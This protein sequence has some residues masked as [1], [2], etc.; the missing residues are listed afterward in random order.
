MV[1]PTSILE[2]ADEVPPM[3]LSSRWTSSGRQVSF[4]VLLAITSLACSLSGEAHADQT[5]YTIAFLTP[6][7]PETE[8]R[9]HTAFEQGL[10]ERGYGPGRNI[11]ILYRFAEGHDELL[12]GLVA[13]LLRLDVDVLLTVG[14]PATRAAQRATKTVPIV[15]VTVLDPV[16]AGFVPPCCSFRGQDP[17]GGRSCQPAGRATDPVRARCKR[18]HR[19][20]A[21]H[22]VSAIDPREGRGVHQVIGSPEN[23]P[24]PDAST[25]QLSLRR[26]A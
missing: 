17:E 24:M 25:L 21:G 1:V 7:T 5:P 18:D 16:H 3:K 10:Q 12:L 14:T 20:E 6:Y 2:R 23:G 4:L 8:A 26:S 19:E 9:W 11:S 13:E 22:Y 15:M